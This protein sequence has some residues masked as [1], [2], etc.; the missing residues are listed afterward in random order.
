[1]IQSILLFC[2][3]NEKLEDHFRYFIIIII[4]IGTLALIT[5]G[6]SSDQIA[7][8]AGLFGTLAGYLVG[9][10]DRGRGMV[11]HG[12]QKQG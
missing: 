11:E 7:P 12:E 1:L 8:A 6:F 10:H 3:P 5:T 2:R 9:R 4:V